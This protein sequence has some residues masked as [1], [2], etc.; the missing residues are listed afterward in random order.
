LDTFS[1]GVRVWGAAPFRV[2]VVHGGPGAVG[3]MAPVARELATERGIVETAHTARS[4]EGQIEELERAIRTAAD[5]PV[6]IVGHSWGAMLAFLFAARR[7]AL[8]ERVILVGSGPYE[9]HYAAGI[10]ETRMSRFTQAERDELDTLTAALDDPARHDRDAIFARIGDLMGR[11][12]AYDPLPH[13]SDAA[14][15]D[16]EVFAQVW[17]EAAELRRRGEL[18]AAGKSIRCPVVAIHGDYDPHPV[19]GIQEPLAATLKD[20]RMIVLDHCG[21]EPW[22]ERQ[23]RDT[24]FRILRAELRA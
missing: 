1:Q 7:P 13:E 14:G 23:A 8:V 10:D 12:D 11:A 16:Y 3:S 17:P 21:H 2:V 22:L 6:T 20:F 18:L 15:F 4:I 5:P 9:D 19:A 24:F